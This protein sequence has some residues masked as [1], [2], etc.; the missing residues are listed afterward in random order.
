MMHNISP[1]AEAISAAVELLNASPDHR[2]LRRIGEGTLTVTPVLESVATRVG[3][4][5]DVETT[6]LDAARDSIIELAAQRFRFDA[7]GRITALGV[8][9]VWREDP[10]RPL[11]P[12]ITKL[13]GL[14]DDDLAG[15]MID[16]AAA[17][18]M[19][20]NADV[21]I[22]HSAVFDAR[23]LEARLPDAA[24]RAWACTLKDVDW[25]GLG[26][27]GRGLG[28]LLSQ[29]GWFYAQ[30]RAEADIGALLH[31]LAHQCPDGTTVLGNLIAW[32]EKPTV[33]IDAID[34]PHSVKD[35]LKS[36]GYSWDPI[37]RFW[38]TEVA[39]AAVDAEQIWLQRNGCN[40]P[41]RLT[42]VTW[43]ERH[44]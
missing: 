22:A 42:P 15:Q 20:R 38:W 23:R 35:A 12:T 19:L 39:E 10:G 5:V 43:F 2:V 13:T 17:T 44:R 3:V 18:T 40:R 41:P 25:P 6:G 26:F 11:D 21:I 29:A 24:G 4:V 7:T 36:R 28:Y 9:R 32:A 37:R 8:A 16:T 14:T 33:R 30:H 27:D 34:T 31:L 1:T